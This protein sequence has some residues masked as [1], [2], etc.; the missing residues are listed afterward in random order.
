MSRHPIA[1]VETS[2]ADPWT[3]RSTRGRVLVVLVTMLAVVAVRGTLDP[4]FEGRVPYV[5]FALASVVVT[6]VA[7]AR[8]GAA[9]LIA[10]WVIGNLLW[11]EPRGV[12]LPWKGA[13]DFAQ[14]TIFFVAGGLLV[15]FMARARRV[16]ERS[17]EALRAR[18]AA[19]TA[20]RAREERLRVSEESLRVALDLVGM[21]TWTVDL[22]TG[23]ATWSERHFHLLGLDPSRAVAGVDTWLASVHPEDRERVAGAWQEARDTGGSFRETY[24]VVWPT[25]AVRWVEARGGFLRDEAGRPVVGTGA[26]HDVTERRQHQE[27]L[28][29]LLANAE[30]LRLE[31]EA[32]RAEAEQAS[33][34]KDH[35]LATL[36]HELRSPLQGMV[37]WIAVLRGARLDADRAARAIDAIE[38][39]VRLQ[40]QLVSDLLDVSRIVAGKL[41]LAMGAVDLS[42]VVEATAE[43]MRPIARRGDVTL[44]TL[45]APHTFVTG[46]A[47]RLQQV[48][49]NLVSNAVKFTRPGGS[50]EV[51]CGQHG[52]DVTIEVIDDGEGIDPAIL[53][54]VFDRFAQGDASPTRRHG[55]LGLG[56]AIVKHLTEAHG[57][58]AAAHSDGVDRGSTFTVTLPAARAPEERPVLAGG[59]AVAGDASLRGLE[60]LLVEDDE[61]S[62]ESLALF[63]QDR[64]ARVIQA[65]C[66]ED[67]LNAFR[68]HRPAVL[69]SDLGLGA[70]DGYRLLEWIR[71]SEGG[72]TVPAIALTGFASA[73]DRTRALAAGFAAHLAKPAQPDE[74]L[75]AL[76][77][78]LEA[79]R[80][81]DA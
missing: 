58:R 56:L 3:V 54:H 67:A 35:F 40:S 76:R 65:S 66:A 80:R 32:A 5:L 49:A 30:R 19:E 64:G 77:R 12:L 53:P 70:V 68:E 24:R 55:G 59:A 9:L 20:R 8:S 18:E 22:R 44:R 78:A 13:A 34:A 21:A 39:S 1:Q 25:G 69:I 7:G 60:V 74:L 42:A 11:V 41:Q 57:G 46:D 45:T 28:E 14:A 63:L 37:G 72:R 29:R 71:A 2:A 17:A 75:A 33:L 50:V 61:A 27:A 10:G 15:A 47:E 79:R 31:A 6:W 43:E 38:R 16:Q 23:H 26:F 73:Q 4:V 81:S 62:R 36:S 51:R 52:S 48:V